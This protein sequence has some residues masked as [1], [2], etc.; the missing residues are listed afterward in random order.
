MHVGPALDILRDTQGPF[1]NSRLPG[2][3]EGDKNPGYDL[4]FV[5]ANKEEM[6]EYW[7]ECLRVTRRGGVVVLDNAIR[8]VS[9]V[10]TMPASHSGRRK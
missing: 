8:K 4:C 5:D 9:C 3:E 7:L 2:A 10:L 1:A 6:L